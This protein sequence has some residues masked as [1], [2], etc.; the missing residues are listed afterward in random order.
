MLSFSCSCLVS[1]SPSQIR[2]LGFECCPLVQKIISMIHDLPCFGMWLVAVFIHWVFSTESLVLCPNPFLQR[3]F[4]IP[5]TP[6]SV[7]VWLQFTVFQFCWWGIS[8]PWGC[9]A[10]CSQRVVGESC[11][12]HAANLFILPIDVQAS[13]E[14]VVVG[15]NGPTFLSAV[16]HIEAFHG[17]GV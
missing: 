15:K 7:H 13:W 2:Q 8:L 3:R 6:S 12:V 11:M 17:L 1:Y 16:Q 5:P 9:A 14:P 10:L 4:S